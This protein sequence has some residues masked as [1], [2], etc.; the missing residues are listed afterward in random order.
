MNTDQLK[1]KFLEIFGGP[2]EGIRVFAAPGRVNL[3][4]EHT[5]YNGG[6]VFP[7]A[8][9]MNTTIIVRS[10][11]D[12]IIKLAAT[13]L[14]DRVEASLGRL[15]DYKRIKWG[16]Y[17]LGVADQLQKNGYKLTG[18][19]MLYHGT[20]PYG[21]GLSSSASI[22]V[23]T[24]LAL[25]TI[26]NEAFSMNRDIGLIEM[27]KIGQKAE[28]IYVGVNCGIMDQFA[29]AMGKA[30]HAILLNARD[31]SYELVPLD[32]KDSKIVITN[33]NKKRSLTDSKY[34]ERR[35]ECE[36]GLEMLKQAFPDANFLGE[37]CYEKYKERQYLIKDEVI[38]KRVQHVMSE[39]NRVLKSVEALNKGDLCEFGNLMVQSHN[40]LRD[41]YEV[42]GLELDT[43]VEEALKI[44]GVVGSR[45]TGAGFG[46][47]TVSIV[48]EDAID[49]FIENVGKGYSERVG[50]K[51]SFYISETGEGAREIIKL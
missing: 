34:N 6:Y 43:L 13:D 48:K 9:T 4:G 26:G 29:S 19:D 28:N 38:K 40:S 42:T 10:R 14:D 12:R 50:L 8:L 46:G 3:I 23:S 32:L 37:I 5:D 7:A 16:N 35:R 45:M 39:N 21:A 11:K 49:K 25:A 1:Q 27:A 47:C 51:A 22:E 20:I 30:N 24:A 31:L 33:T 44:D 2:E 41:F 36:D 15:E 17:Q 18:C